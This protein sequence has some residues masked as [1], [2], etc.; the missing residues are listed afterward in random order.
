MI[1]LGMGWG[2]AVLVALFIFWR[3]SGENTAVFCYRMGSGLYLLARAGNWRPLRITRGEFAPCS[4]P[5]AT[6]S[7]RSTT[8]K[9]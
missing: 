4:N 3:E 5:Y 7:T 1:R 9:G 8:L 2:Y 6:C